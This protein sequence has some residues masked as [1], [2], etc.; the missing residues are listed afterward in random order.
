MCSLQ[1]AGGEW[2]VGGEGARAFFLYRDE[3]GESKI[4][5]I[6]RRNCVHRCKICKKPNLSRGALIFMI[7]KYWHRET[8]TPSHPVKFQF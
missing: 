8:M 3:G 4:K 5:I 7:T 2:N 6:N 1:N